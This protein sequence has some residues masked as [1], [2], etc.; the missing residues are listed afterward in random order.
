MLGMHIPCDEIEKLKA[1][2]EGELSEEDVPSQKISEK[3]ENVIQGTK[4]KYKKRN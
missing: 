1:L 4:R 3:I 2:F